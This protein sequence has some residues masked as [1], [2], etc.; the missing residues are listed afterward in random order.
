MLA[1]L[2]TPRRLRYRKA[3]SVSEVLIASLVNVVQVEDDSRLARM[4]HQEPSLDPQQNHS[5]QTHDIVNISRFELPKILC[6][7][8]P[9]PS[10]VSSESASPLLPLLLYKMSTTTL[11]RRE[12]SESSTDPN[13]QHN[14]DTETHARNRTGKSSSSSG[15][16]GRIR[17]KLHFDDEILWKKF[18]SRRLQLVE[19]LSL[20]SKKA[21]EQDHE[22]SICARTLMSEF[23]FDESKLAEFD[24]LVRLAIQS[25]RRNKKRSEKRLASKMADDLPKLYI[26]TR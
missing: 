1:V 13:N 11:S 17:E 24:K 5:T 2:C 8:S 3:P 10:A 18:S 19:S 15:A 26:I 9:S 14:S 6:S 16:T 22:I 4:I 20:S 7:S 12:E 25:V 23:N 21:S